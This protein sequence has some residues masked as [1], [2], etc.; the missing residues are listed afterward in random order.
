M[1]SP[2]LQFGFAPQRPTQ[3]RASLFEPIAA[4]AAICRRQ[5][6]LITVCAC[7]GGAAGLV[8]ALWEPG[9]Y[10]AQATMLLQSAAAWSDLHP[11]RPA[12]A[13]DSEAVATTEG[14]LR[15]PELLRASVLQLPEGL[16]TIA[17]RQ[18]GARQWS[19]AVAGELTRRWQGSVQVMHQ[20]ATHLITVTFDN[21]D[22]RICAAIPN[23]IIAN[24][25]RWRHQQ[26]QRQ[27]RA[28]L[29]TLQSEV[30]VQ[31]GAYAR[32]Q[33]Q[34]TRFLR[35]NPAL[36]MTA[37]EESWQQL[38]TAKTAAEIEYWKRQANLASGYE[39]DRPEERSLSSM[40]GAAADVRAQ[41]AAL[42]RQYAPRALPLA[43]ARQRL[44]S[45]QHSIELTER[46][47]RQQQQ[48]GARRQT[49]EVAALQSALLGQPRIISAAAERRAR[50]QLLQDQA[51]AHEQVLRNLLRHEQ[52]LSTLMA[53]PESGAVQ[54]RRATPPGEVAWPKPRQDGLFCMALGGAIGL[55]LAALRSAHNDAQPANQPPRAAVGERAWF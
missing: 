39:G 43:Q 27:M 22:A 53:L 28:S 12:S 25:Q 51:A 30:G 29:A 52:E 26:Q 47:R 15:N 8:W 11:V 9:H 21:T 36:P 6:L 45:L 5:W 50:L 54:V 1:A 7:V 23:L 34:V 42:A 49:L 10:R 33:E 18:A 20:P 38:Q 31:V 32:A 17:L 19:P 40:R 35:S 4:V 2:Q 37:A 24:Y 41:T 16:R 14:L 46:E 55:L 13:V 48:A 44:T 3:N